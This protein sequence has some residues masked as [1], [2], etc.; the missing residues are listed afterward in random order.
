MLACFTAA[1]FAMLISSSRTRPSNSGGLSQDL[2]L[3]CVSSRLYRLACPLFACFEIFLS[4]IRSSI[5]RLVGLFPEVVGCSASILPQPL[6]R[7]GSGL[8]SQE[9]THRRAD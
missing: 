4:S 5:N 9:H 6:P 2:L 7:C 1:R 8:W 3:D